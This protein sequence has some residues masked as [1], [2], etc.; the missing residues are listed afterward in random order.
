MYVASFCA[1]RRGG[2][3]PPSNILLA[4]EASRLLS[5]RMPAN[6]K[7]TMSKKSITSERRDALRE[8]LQ[9]ATD[10]LHRRRASEIAVDAID[11]YV[12]LNWLEW[13]GGALRLTTTGENICH[14]LRLAIETP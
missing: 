7:A 11:D 8:G 1:P 12:T 6:S 14:Q 2:H 4:A 10:A 13:W 5:K 9:S 3:L